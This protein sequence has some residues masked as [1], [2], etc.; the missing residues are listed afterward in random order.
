MQ[1]ELI[2]TN[3]S[4][5]LPGIGAFTQETL[6]QWPLDAAIAEKLGQCVLAA[7]RHAIEQAYPAGGQGSIELTVREQGGKLE[8]IVRDYGLPQD[9]ASLERQLHD[10]ASPAA[11]KI[12]LNW[13]GADVV[14]ELH[15][16]GYGREGKAIQLVKWLHDDHITDRA[17][18]A[19]LA[20]F[21]DDA[22]LAPA[23]EYTIRRMR[24]EEAIQVSQLM[25]RAYGNTYFNEDVYY[26]D[27]VAAH[28]AAGSVLSFVAVGADGQLAGHYALERGEEGPVAEGGQAVV[29]PAHRGRGLL[30]R[31]KDAALADAK[32]LNLVGVYADAVTV[33]TRTQQSD[34]KHGAHLTCVDL[35]IS[36]R[37]ES[38][39]N[40]SN[41]LPQRLT[42]LLFFQW[43]Q[44]PHC[45]PPTKPGTIYVPD[46]HREMIEKIYKN[47]EC[48]VAFGTPAAAAGHGTLTV[49][50]DSG[51]A[52]AFMRAGEIG[53]D[54]V[55]L[56]RHA[57]RE[58]I[59]RSHA[60]ALYAELPLADPATPAIAAE[61]EAEGF[62][63]LG[64]APCFSSRGD[65]L[66]LAYL[67]EPLA[68]APIQTADAFTAELVDYV[69]AEQ[70]RVQAAL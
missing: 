3:D 32:R 28:N 47:L 21:Q 64:V 66:R 27:R 38:F 1:L 23:Q 24:P 10:S 8:F 18:P 57:K 37:N 59:E 56:I 16:I 15:W 65:V 53:A 41:E 49:K 5:F 17:H 40:I 33:H 6:K 2:F 25:Y 9:V 26:P 35:A 63:L 46:R 54:T 51:A 44:P 52:C 12:A 29:D 69:L 4:R 36:P 50:I 39:K 13:P 68:R 7:A 19:A 22:P 70:A 55:Q 62:G 42:C 60:E 34:V 43:L 30:D 11:G 20:P 67:V 48:P 45:L 14:D 61:L 58:I 31:M